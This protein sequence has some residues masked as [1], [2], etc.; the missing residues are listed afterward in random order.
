MKMHVTK[1]ESLKMEE[2]KKKPR[3]SEKEIDILVQGVKERS[4]IIN[5]KFSDVVNNAKKKQSW[6]E[7]MEAVNAVSFSRRTIDELKKKW[8]DLKRGTKKRASAVQRERTKTGGG[9][10]KIVPLSS[11][12]KEV[13][14]VMGEERIFGFSAAV[15]TMNP[16]TPAKPSSADIPVSSDVPEA[17]QDHPFSNS[18][19][20]ITDDNLEKKRKIAR[21]Y[22]QK[23]SDER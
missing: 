12:E 15:D 4:E 21:P 19:V 5:S 10:L 7:I 22:S 9:K 18:S 2:K 11:M 3:F 13:V 17:V 23:E 8:D 20:Q 1:S 16:Q 14:S 6:I